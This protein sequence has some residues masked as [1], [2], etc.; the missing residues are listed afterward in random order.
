MQGLAIVGVN[1][2]HD[3]GGSR[4]WQSAPAR[5]GAHEVVDGS[6]LILATEGIVRIEA[7]YD[8]VAQRIAG[9]HVD[10]RRGRTRD[11]GRGTQLWLTSEGGVL[12]VNQYPKGPAGLGRCVA[13]PYTR[14]LTDGHCSSFVN[15]AEKAETPRRALALVE[16]FPGTVA[17]GP[18]L[19]LAER[20]SGL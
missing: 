19:M 1:A 14:V 6:N 5:R 12:R 9:G 11:R 8:D 15:L 16:T 17:Q 2:V 20:F 13:D 3:M 7:E 4:A 18:V 10:R